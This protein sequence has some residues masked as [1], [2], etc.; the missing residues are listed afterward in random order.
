MVDDQALEVLKSRLTRLEAE[1]RRFKRIGAASIFGVI[2]MAVM[3]Q[4]ANP[5]SKVVEAEK[6]VVRDAKGVVR[7]VLGPENPDGTEQH[8]STY[9]NLKMKPTPVGGLLTVGGLLADPASSKILGPDMLESILV[10]LRGP[11]GLHVYSTDGKHV[12]GVWHSDFLGNPSSI[13]RLNGAVTTSSAELR[14]ADK[15]HT[16]LV[17][18]A[19]EET[20]SERRARRAEWQKKADAAK[21]EEERFFLL[22]AGPDEE[23]SVSLSASAS[24]ASVTL[25]G[26]RLRTGDGRL[27]RPGDGRRGL[28]LGTD[29]GGTQIALR[30]EHGRRRAIL[31]QVE[32]E[33][34]TTGVKEQR[35]VSSLV[36]FDK[37]GKAFWKVP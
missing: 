27:L 16:A 32:L 19:T 23:G 36:L 31:G 7:V 26:P 18:H 10:Q 21:S 33:R 9:E 5:A 24:G 37:D 11:F 22:L 29:V 3:G 13:L 34:P 2:A 8:R 4:A 35:P 20:P 28:Q 6:F 14:V 30:D 15:L 25:D 17:L 12:A 1:N